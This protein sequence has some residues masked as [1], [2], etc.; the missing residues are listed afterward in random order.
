MIHVTRRSFCA[1]SFFWCR[2][3]S[4]VEA[5]ITTSEALG[6]ILKSFKNKGRGHDKGIL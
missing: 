5:A 3:L 2:W 1:A 6:I 4:Q